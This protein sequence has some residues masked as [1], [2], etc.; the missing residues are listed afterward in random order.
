M[1]KYISTILSQFTQA[2]R[3][4]A[5]LLLL[6]SI[7][8]ITIGP[9][10]I[11]SITMDRGEL[12]TEISKRDARITALELEIDTLST[13]VRRN[14]RSCT[15]EIAAREEDFIRM[16]NQLKRELQ[17]SEPRE[18]RMMQIQSEDTVMV[19]RSQPK[20]IHTNANTKALH[21]IESMKKDL[22][23]Q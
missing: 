23:S 15:N 2:Q 9:S 12:M 8:F 13:T 16:L 6:V 14:Q 17:K 1:F 11:S 18:L 4:I 10:L 19:V 3:I 7:V 20:V 21:M 5:L 22:K